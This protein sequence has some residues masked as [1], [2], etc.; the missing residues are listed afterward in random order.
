MYKKVLSLSLLLAS[1]PVI[2]ADNHFYQGQATP[3]THHEATSGGVGLLVGTLAGGPIG[4]IIGGSMGVMIGNQQTKNDTIIT[5]EQAISSLEQELSQTMAALAQSKTAT[6]KA[7]TKIA[8]LE[9]IH[10]NIIQQNREDLIN[11]SNTYLLDIYFLTNSTV[12]TPHVQQGLVR[13]A[14]LL[15]TNPHFHANIE[16]HSDWRGSKD[17]NFQLAKQRLSAVTTELTQA[18]SP[19]N[20]LLT[21]NYGE[22]KNEHL[23]SWGE[24]LFYDRRVSITLSYF[25]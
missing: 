10:Q 21:T 4:A 5:R 17:I 22:N 11:V 23:G 24:D 18:G 15:K 13:L 12:I 6:E 1:S 3:K 25:E 2:M 9:S 20:Q 14:E 16:A 19:S 7:N 8:E